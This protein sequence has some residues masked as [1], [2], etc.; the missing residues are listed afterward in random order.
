MQ[1]SEL[2]KEIKSIK[3]DEV[4]KDTESYFEAVTLSLELPKLIT[5]LEKFFG[6]PVYPSK[7]ELNSEA[8]AI[9]D[10]FGGVRPNQI[11]YFSNQEGEVIFAMLWPWSD[12]EHTTIKI[13][14]NQ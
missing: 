11:L 10:N 4:R 9:A 13:G 6:L 3:F 1:I 8:Q 5:I 14:K 12:E 7:N 2:R